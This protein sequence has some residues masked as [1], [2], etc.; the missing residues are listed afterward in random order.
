MSQEVFYLDVNSAIS[1]RA[2][3]ITITITNYHRRNIMRHA[4]FAVIIG[5]ISLFAVS[6]TSKAVSLND[7]KTVVSDSS[8]AE[9]KMEKKKGKKKKEGA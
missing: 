7:D 3:K 5:C 2:E 1:P 4:L 8:K 9:K 6:S